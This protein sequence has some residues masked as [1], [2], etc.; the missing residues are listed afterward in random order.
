MDALHVYQE[1]KNRTDDVYLKAFCVAKQNLYKKNPINI[2]ELKKL[3]DQL[4]ER[5]ELALPP[6]RIVKNLAS[7]YYFDESENPYTFDRAYAEKKI[8]KWETEKI[9][10]TDGADRSGDFFLSKVI[11][12]LIP[13]STLPDD[14]L[15]QYSKIAEMID[16][17]QLKEIYSHLSS[18]QR[19]NN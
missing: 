1:F 17:S 8:K 16:Q 11:N 2:F 4:Q 13:S 9:I 6:P 14:T 5:L 3:D 12:D 19:S 7:V 18:A 10:D 15:A